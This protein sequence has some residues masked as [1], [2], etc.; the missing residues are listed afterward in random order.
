[1]DA[2]RTGGCRLS[3]LFHDRGV[4][5]VTARW[6]LIPLAMI[7]SGCDSPAERVADDMWEDGE[8]ACEVEGFDVGLRTTIDELEGKAGDDL[9][10]LTELTLVSEPPDRMTGDELVEFFTDDNNFEEITHQVPYAQITVCRT[11]EEFEE[12]FLLDVE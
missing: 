3:L 5:P 2:G 6:I 11:Q 7:C 9:V 1:M 4:H 8:R 12:Y 10:T